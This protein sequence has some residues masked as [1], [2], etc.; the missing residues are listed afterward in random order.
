MDDDLEEQPSLG[1]LLVR[2]GEAV[3]RRFVAALASL[4]LRPRELR[5]LVLI[6]RHPGSTQRALSRRMPSDPGN[7]VELLDR[8]EAQ[9]RIARRRDPNDRR[10]R[11]PELTPEGKA[12]LGRAIAASAEAEREALAPL[13]DHERAALETIAL[14]LWRSNRETRAA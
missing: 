4:Q 6:D 1:F 8:L 7:L 2:L 14:R 3:D 5:A 12:L 9:G 10:R 13:D 11:T